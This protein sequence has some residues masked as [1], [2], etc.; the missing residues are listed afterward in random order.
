MIADKDRMEIDALLFELADFA[1]LNDKKRCFPDWTRESVK[2]FLLLHLGQK[3]LLFVRVK[4]EIAGLTV[5]WRW[6]KDE[7]PDLPDDEIFLNP[8]PY[9]TDG[10]L[11]YLS[12]VVTTLPRVM[13]SMGREFVNRNP[14]YDDCEIWA[15]RQNKKTGKA[16]RVQ[17]TKR[18][19]DF[20]NCED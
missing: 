5:W 19:L 7:I 4:G 3:T 11:I 1:L 8:P 17:Y 10:D 9:R 2:N 6:N 14:D 20:I 16:E 18:L 12:D 13:R 15:I